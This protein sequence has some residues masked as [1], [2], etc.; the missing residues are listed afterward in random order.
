[1]KV[2]AGQRPLLLSSSPFIIEKM[3]RS[4]DHPSRLKTFLTLSLGLVAISSGA[5]LVRFSQEAP[6]L[7]I[8][9]YRMTWALLILLPFYYLSG[10]RIRK[11][12]LDFRL[13]VAGIALAL[14]FAFWITS[15]AHTSVAVSV[16]LVNTSPVLVAILSYLLFS[17]RLTSR[18]I[19]GIILTIAGSIVLVWRDLYELG[20]FKGA[21]LALLGSLMLG[22]YLVA[23]RKIRSR[24]GLLDYVVPVYLIAALVLGILVYAGGHAFG[25]YSPRTHIFMFSLGLF[26]QALGHT[27]YNW[28]LRYLPATLVSVVIVLEPFLASIWA[29]WLL[30]ERVTPLVVA[31]GAMVACG[32]IV[33]SRKGFRND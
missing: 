1:M 19:A 26:P 32:I 5:I 33:I 4:P 30:G 2:K 7:V 21:L 31:G 17:E 22:I 29:W 23:G 11:T 20:D 18:G 9:F 24:A 15:L 12:G 28:G 8:S 16:L 3:N 6:S 14:H 27:S 10:R 13:F 25:G